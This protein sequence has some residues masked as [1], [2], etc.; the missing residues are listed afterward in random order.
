[1]IFYF[2]KQLEIVYFY[3]ESK[4]VDKANNP[5]YKT[6]TLFDRSG[7]KLAADSQTSLYI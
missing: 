1:M 3:F 2:L 4:Q 6:S 5:S 7:E